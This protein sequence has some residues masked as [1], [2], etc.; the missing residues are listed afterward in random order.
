MKCKT[1]KETKKS[2]D[3]LNARI[4]LC[5]SLG[6]FFSKIQESSI[7]LLLN[8]FL[9]W[10]KMTKKRILCFGDSNTWGYVP[11]TDHER[12]SEDVR[13]PKVLQKLLGDKFEIIEEGLNSRTLVNEDKR[14]EKEGRNGSQYLIP[15]LDS[16]DPLDLVILM[17]G[18]NELKHKFQNSPEEI[19]N[20]LNKYFVKVI[21]NR[22]SQFRRTFPQLLIISLPILNEQT[23]YASQRYV[24]GNKKSKKLGEIYSGIAKKNKCNFVSASELTVGGDG[25]HLT[26]ESHIKLAKKLSEKIKSIK[27]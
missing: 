9:R 23:D 20:L 3:T 25:V 11:C 26:K 1:H 8:N 21:L 22:K 17:L 15:S 14:L 18:T 24:G 7:Y 19:G 12:F 6:G 27:L 4:T 10:Y 5:A 16:H 13:F 2:S